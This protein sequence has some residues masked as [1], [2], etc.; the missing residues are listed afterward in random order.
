[1]EVMFKDS[2]TKN[3]SFATFEKYFM[4]SL[5]TNHADYHILFYKE[6]SNELEFSFSWENFIIVCKVS[7]EQMQEIFKD[8]QDSDID[9][10][11][12]KNMGKNPYVFK[13][14]KQYLFNRAIPEF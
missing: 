4:E 11:E 12:A 13:F 3:I 5:N 2:N 9:F 14:L 6:L 7:L 1:M 10:V 8:I